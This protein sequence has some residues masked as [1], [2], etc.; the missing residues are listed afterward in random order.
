MEELG[1]GYQQLCKMNPTIIHAS[2]SGMYDRVG[3]AMRLS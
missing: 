2:I 1:I 3:T